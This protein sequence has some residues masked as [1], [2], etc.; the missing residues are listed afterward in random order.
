V[1]DLC[2]SHDPNLKRNVAREVFRMNLPALTQAYLST[3]NLGD[4]S[5]APVA[6]YTGAALPLS[7]KSPTL[8]LYTDP[9]A[10]PDLD[11]QVLADPFAPQ[12]DQR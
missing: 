11:S 9:A 4:D 6:V 7:Q 5:A 12:G 8:N 2:G 3:D 1:V 10:L